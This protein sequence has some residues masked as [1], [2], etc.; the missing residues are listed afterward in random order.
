MLP[1]SWLGRV[2]AV[3]WLLIIVLWAQF[4]IASAEEKEPQAVALG[5]IV[6][7]M[8]F[9]AGLTIWGAR[10]RNLRR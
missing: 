5:A 4:A 9:T 8:L 2:T 6:A 7:V 1:S 10:R 3:A